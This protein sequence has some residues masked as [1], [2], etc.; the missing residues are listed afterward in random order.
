MSTTLATPPR[1]PAL[2]TTGPEE[3]KLV[4]A[5]NSRAW[6]PRLPGQ[7]IFYPVR[8]EDYA[9]RIARDWN[10]KHSGVG[11]VT[12]FEVES[13]FL[14]RYPVRQAGGE[15][16]LEL[17]VPAEELDEFNAHIVGEIQVVHEFR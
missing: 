12:R 3:L 9:I 14:S 11:F 1:V 17:W 13:E 4:R 10:V 7:P 5:L 6:P 8:N 2:R 15:T 16:I